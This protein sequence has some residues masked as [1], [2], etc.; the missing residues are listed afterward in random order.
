MTNRQGHCKGVLSVASGLLGVLRATGLG[1]QRPGV[2]WPLGHH[3]PPPPLPDL[4]RVRQEVGA[5]AVRSPSGLEVHLPS[6][7]AGQRRK[8]GLAQ[9]REGTVPAGTPS[10]SERYWGAHIREAPIFSLLVSWT[11]N[12]GGSFGNLAPGFCR[13]H[14]RPAPTTLSP[15]FSRAFSSPS[16]PHAAGGLEGARY[17]AGTGFMACRKVLTP[18][19]LVRGPEHSW[20]R[21]WGGGVTAPLGRVLRVT[22]LSVEQPWASRNPGALETAEGFAPPTGR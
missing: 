2:A 19:E 14:P 20:R 9:H 4:L 13:S 7:T 17:G 10:F 5:A 16:W 12:W 18:T 8:Q 6:P 11:Q 1:C 15:A 3:G 21:M 22:A